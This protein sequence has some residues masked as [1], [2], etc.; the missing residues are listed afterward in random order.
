LILRGGGHLAFGDKVGDEL[1]DLCFRHFFGMAFIVIEDVFPG[2]LY[3][4]FTSARGVLPDLN[5]V[6]VLVEEFFSF[7]GDG[8][9]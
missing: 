9:I 3:V 4:G 6:A 8:R 7:C 1:V 2:P 5:G